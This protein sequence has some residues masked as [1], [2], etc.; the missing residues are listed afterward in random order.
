MQQDLV[1]DD[2]LE[3]TKNLAWWLYM[4]HAVSFVFSL[5][6]FSFVPLI[7]NY[8]KRDDALGTFVHSHHGWM[9]RSFWW[10]FCWMVLGGLLALTVVGLLLAV[11]I[12]VGAW[13]WKAYRLLKGFLDLN[14]NKA[15]PV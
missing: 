11:P 9:I 3:A 8:L 7:I 13:I 4:G 2:R 10:Y 1:L 12:W 15:M 5:G 14:E 6:T